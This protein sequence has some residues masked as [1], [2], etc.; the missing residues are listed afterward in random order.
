M[1]LGERKRIGPRVL[2]NKLNINK[3]V[4]DRL[5]R[6]TKACGKLQAATDKAKSQ[7]AENAEA[8]GM[9]ATE[10]Q[11]E[12]INGSSSDNEPKKRLKED[13]NG[14]KKSPD[15]DSTQR[16]PMGEDKSGFTKSPDKDSIQ[17]LTSL[18]NG[19]KE[20]ISPVENKKCQD[21]DDEIQK[22]TATDL[23]IFKQVLR[24][25]IE[26]RTKAVEEAVAANSIHLQNR[27]RD[28]ERENRELQW[29]TRKLFGAF[30]KYVM[31]NE[32]VS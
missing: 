32:M 19:T 22:Q 6:I 11:Q 5:R 23:Q 14:I 3:D 29:N 1:T 31:E 18:Q 10:N 2:V 15:K 7:T 12:V 30:K 16:T 20:N 8:N 21:D 13:V 24:E 9:K 4:I 26:Q 17:S 27:I 28:L 25:V